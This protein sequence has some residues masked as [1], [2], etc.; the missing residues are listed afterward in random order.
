MAHNAS[1]VH[2]CLG[3]AVRH[4]THSRVCMYVCSSSRGRQEIS[5]GYTLTRLTSL[6]SSLMAYPGA[7]AKFAR[8]GLLGEALLS[9]AGLSA[10]EI[11]RSHLSGEPSYITRC[12]SLAVL[13]AEV[14][15]H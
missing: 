13:V 15:V 8:A 1:C 10:V 14:P 11:S 9:I 5:T 3:L 12:S 6:L 4:S 2:A 7:P